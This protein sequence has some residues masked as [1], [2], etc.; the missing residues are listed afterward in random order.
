MKRREFMSFVVSV[1]AC[2]RG[3][4]AAQAQETSK[5]KR[6]GFLRIGPPPAA[7]IEAL[8]QGLRELGHIE[9]Q[10]IAIEFG[11]PS[12]AAQLPEAA[13]RLVQ[14]KVDVIF[15]SGTPPL[16]KRDDLSLNRFGIPKSVDL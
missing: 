2:S 13:A 14:L 7:W 4:L 12:S 8:R 1:A 9:G 16:L 11:L 15:A 10:N 6:I 3:S 5:F